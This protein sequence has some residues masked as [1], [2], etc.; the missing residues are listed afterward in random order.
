MLKRAKSVTDR[1]DL[2]EWNDFKKHSK[3]SKIDRAKA[4]NKKINNL[5]KPKERSF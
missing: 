5:K 2:S 4:L 1:Y 3:L